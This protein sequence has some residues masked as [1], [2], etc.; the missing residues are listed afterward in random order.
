MIKKIFTIL[1]SCFL[2]A[3]EANAQTT[4]YSEK[5]AAT[6]MSIWKDSFALDGKPAKWTY[7]EGVILEG[8]EGLWK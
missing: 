5:V 6:A 1:F 8:I 4:N 3:F 7:D 2:F